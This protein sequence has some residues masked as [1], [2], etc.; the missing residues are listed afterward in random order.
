MPEKSGKNSR[1]AS[2]GRLDDSL[3]DRIGVKI[4]VKNRC[5]A[6]FNSNFTNLVARYE[7]LFIYARVDLSLTKLSHNLP[8]PE[9]FDELF[10][11]NGVYRYN[12]NFIIHRKCLRQ[13]VCLAL[14]K[15]PLGR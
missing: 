6:T 3:G 15:C 14:V 1:R 4:W 8:K 9:D 11:E 10:A 12:I 2:L 5:V 7:V 13:P